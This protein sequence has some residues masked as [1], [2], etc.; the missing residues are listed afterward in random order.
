M[1]LWLL[2]AYLWRKA[3]H[4]IA[5]ISWMAALLYLPRLFV[6]H[7]AAEPGSEMSET[8]EV[9]ERRLGNAIMPPA[10]IASFP[11][12]VLM[13]ATPGT[14]AYLP[15]AGWSLWI[16]LVL[17]VCLVFVH[18]RRPSW[19]A[20]LAADRNRRPQRFFRI[21]NEVPTLLMI[22]TVVWV[23]ARPL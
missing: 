10:M 21:L 2:Q 7:C 15:T 17:V 19:R 20:D 18:L 5:V 14:T 8:F 23:I 11:L 3:L 1:S 6:Y 16:H 4:I 13:L 9:V 22:G 12:G